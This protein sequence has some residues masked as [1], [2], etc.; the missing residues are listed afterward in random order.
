MMCPRD[1]RA[2]AQHF[3]LADQIILLGAKTIQAQGDWNAMKE[4][5]TEIRKYMLEQSSAKAGLDGNTS[6]TSAVKAQANTDAAEDLSRRV[7]DLSLY[8]AS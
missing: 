1:L 4:K 5:S 2:T 7:G 8:R 6:S 3:R